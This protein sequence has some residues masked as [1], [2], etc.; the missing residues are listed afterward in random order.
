MN[1]EKLEWLLNR[2]GKAAFARYYY[3]LKN[4]E[5]AMMAGIYN[6]AGIRIR[7]SYA[8]QIFNAHREYDALRIIMGA[9]RVQFDARKI[10]AE[11][12]R[13]ELGSA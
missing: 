1:D 7:Q 8:R 13:K 9:A 2:I 3:E 4:D 11:I 5:P 12:L 10:A 6:D